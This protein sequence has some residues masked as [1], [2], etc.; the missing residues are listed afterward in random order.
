MAFSHVV[1]ASLSQAAAA[2][3]KALGI[4]NDADLASFFLDAQSVMDVSTD[5]AVINEVFRAWQLACMQFQAQQQPSADYKEQLK[6]PLPPPAAQPP[7]LGARPKTRLFAPA[8]LRPRNFT[9][10]V[11]QA[12]KKQPLARTDGREAC[13]QA[14]FKT[15]ILCGSAN[16]LYGTDL[17]LQQS[18]A[19]PLF[20]RKFQSCSDERLL[21][22]RAAMRLWVEWHGRHAPIDQPFW[23]PSAV[24]LSSYFQAISSNGPTAAPGAVAALTWWRRHVGVPFPLQDAHWASPTQGHVAKPREPL[25]LRVMLS[26][27]RAGVTASGS[28]KS[29]IC[30]A[31]LPLVACLYR[32][33]Q[34]SQNLHVSFAFLRATCRKGKRRVQYTQPPFD[35]ACP[36]VLPFGLDMAAQVLLDHSETTRALGQEPDF[37][38]P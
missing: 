24:T 11:A 36:S 37:C 18:E 22:H 15:A 38:H 28:V 30:H 13:L 5:E 34:R 16:T 12:P 26:L 8:S 32:H 6:Q 31:L 35:W 14:M 2:A 29:L 20:D 4:E 25:L 19:R 23:K 21:S 9:A 1:Q 3:L 27:C 7:F 10:V 17:V 33:L